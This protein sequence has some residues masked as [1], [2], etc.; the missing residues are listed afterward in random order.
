MLSLQTQACVCSRKLFA[1]KF[2]L[3][4]SMELSRVVSTTV[5]VGIE[6]IASQPLTVFISSHSQTGMESAR[7]HI[8]TVGNRYSLVHL[9]CLRPFLIGKFIRHQ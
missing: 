9:Q 3:A 4:V 5:A 7:V 2:A 8:P 6:I 1:L